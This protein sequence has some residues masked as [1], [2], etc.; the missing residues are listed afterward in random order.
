LFQE[1]ELKSQYAQQ[2]Y[3]MSSRLPAS[4]ASVIEEEGYGL[5]AGCRMLIPGIT[6]ELIELAFAMPGATPTDGPAAAR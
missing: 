6:S 2:L 1:N 5:E 3:R 4:Y